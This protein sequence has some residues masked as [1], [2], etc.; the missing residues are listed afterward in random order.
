LIAIDTNVLLR[1][2]LHDDARQT[3]RAFTLVERAAAA[4]DELFVA[5]V[6]LCETLW[7]LRSTHHVARA[8]LEATVRDLLKVRRFAFQSPDAAARALAAFAAGRGDFADYF[9]REHAVA[10]GCEYVATFDQALLRE[11]GFRA[12]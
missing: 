11:D 10:A 9:I 2:I 3:A 8:D 5:D 12:P 7:V 6:V 1:L 4:G